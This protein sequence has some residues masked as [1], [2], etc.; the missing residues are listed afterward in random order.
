[1]LFS[2]LYV[3]F[4]DTFVAILA[5][6]LPAPGDVAIKVGEPVE[7]NNFY[8]SQNMFVWQSFFIKWLFFNH[9]YQKVGDPDPNPSEE[10][11]H[12]VYVRY[13]A[14]LRNL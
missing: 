10:K 1:M 7:V 5:G 2:F 6:N 12:A 13:L 3:C 8:F 14:A 4:Y 11:V 9:M